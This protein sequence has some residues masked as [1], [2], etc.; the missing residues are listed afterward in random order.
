MS[1]KKTIPDADLS[2]AGDD[3]HILW[4]IKKSLDL[5]NFDERG[6]QAVTIEGV[7]ENASKKLDPYGEKFLGIDLTEYYGGKDFKSAD[8]ICISQLKY[9]TRR[10]DENFTYSKLYNGKK[11]YKGS[12]IH[13]LATTF[14]AFLDEY[15]RDEVIRKTTIKLVS[16]RSINSNVSFPLNRT[17]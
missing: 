8:T 2:S 10:A 15:G 3:F 13:R 5:L 6:L 11:S 9:S 7:E 16:N 17:V 4:A 1:I 14:K 12:I